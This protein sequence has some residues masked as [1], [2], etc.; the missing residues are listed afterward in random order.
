MP[1]YKDILDA[2]AVLGTFGAVVTSLYL[3]SRTD[4]RIHAEATDR[5]NLYAARISV[6]LSQLLAYVRSWQAH[7]VFRDLTLTDAAA[8]RA[9]LRLHKR[10]A[11]EHLPTVPMEFLC[12]LSPLPNNCAH[13]IA[14][15]L[16][17]LELLQ[18]RINSI[19]EPEFGER[20]PAHQDRILDDL[21]G[22][23][24][25]AEGLLKMTSAECTKAANIGA[26]RPTSEELY[27]AYE[28]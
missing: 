8:R 21:D 5:S 20:D 7:I 17:C 4:G 12:A 24:N 1:T 18:S 10:L 26:P 16:D 27:G 23:L 19:H 22:W 13:R 15:A 9:Q 3:A 2:L 28:E 11:T 6:R 25:E 14:R